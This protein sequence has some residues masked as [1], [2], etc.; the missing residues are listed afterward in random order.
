MAVDAN[1][2]AC[3]APGCYWQ[4]TGALTNFPKDDLNNGSCAGVA[5]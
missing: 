3:A 4:N 2:N 5:P 1:G